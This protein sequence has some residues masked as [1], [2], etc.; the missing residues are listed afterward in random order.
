MITSSHHESKQREQKQ[1]QKQKS[2][3]EMEEKVQDLE[4]EAKSE[5]KIANITKEEAFAA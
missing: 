5:F 2:L 1:K 3:G 4:T